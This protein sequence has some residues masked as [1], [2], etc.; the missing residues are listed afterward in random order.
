MAKG[1]KR[2]LKKVLKRANK[3][4]TGKFCGEGYVGGY[5]EAIRD[6]LAAL[7]GYYTPETRG[8]WRDD[9]SD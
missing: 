5:C 9:N 8:W 6:V 2:K 7:D 1:I 3:E 4:D